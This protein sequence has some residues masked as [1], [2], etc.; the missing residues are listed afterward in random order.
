[1]VDWIDKTAPTVT[2][3]DPT[4][5]NGLLT[6]DNSQTFSASVNETVTSCKLNLGAV[7]SAT[8]QVSWYHS[9]PED[10]NGSWHFYSPTGVDYAF[11][12][13]FANA[14][15]WN[16][17]L[18]P[19][20]YDMTS[21]FAGTQLGGVWRFQMSDNVGRDGGAITNINLVL[22]GIN[23]PWSGSAGVWDYHTTVVDIPV[24][25]GSLS[26]VYDMNR[27]DDGTY[28]VEVLGI[29]DGVTSYYVVCTDSAT[30]EGNSASRS[31]TIDTTA[32]VLSGKSEF[33]DGWYNSDQTSTFTYTDTNGIASGN[34]PSCTIGTE[35]SS[36]TCSVIPNVCDNAGNCNTESVTSNG[37]NIDKY[38]P[39][40]TADPAA[41]DYTTG[42]L[43]TLTG[44]DFGSGLRNIFYTT[45][46]TTPDETSTLFITGTPIVVDADVTINA[47]AY[48]NLDNASD[49]LVA[50]YRIVPEQTQNDSPSVG[51]SI[52]SNTPPSCNDTKPGSAPRLLSAIAGTNSVTLNW[53]AASTPVSYYLVTY[54]DQSGS[55][56]FGNPNV[57]G[58][59]TTSYTVNGLSGGKTYFFKVRAGNGCMPG[60][61]SNEVS[62]TPAGGFVTTPAEGFEAGV[63]GTETEATPSAT[64]SITEP[65]P[66]I[67]GS[68]DDKGN[69]S[70]MWI[71]LLVPLYFGG[72]LIFKKK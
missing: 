41:G 64:P 32:P 15:G 26:G 54:G 21:V 49:I 68:Q 24:S 71:F 38:A 62:A 63:L 11:T 10:T 58:S 13:R 6:S 43:V 51:S 69:N 33:G 66:E 27:N 29:A 55:Q 61:F 37:A 17:I 1:M 35:G 28:S 20:V 44:T 53:S 70:W 36:Q 65:T 45:D 2:L 22:N 48:D 4:P 34:E 50:A 30:N 12:D 5:S 67:L 8:S 60:D 14:G 18:S 72:R 39:T 31:L 7:M 19:V 56:Q 42:Q 57:G 3:I 9:F 47:V 52:G 40:L 46:G 23:Y 25:G 59:G 16:Q